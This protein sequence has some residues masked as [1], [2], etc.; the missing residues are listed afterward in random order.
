MK[1]TECAN[2]LYILGREGSVGPVPSQGLV[3]CLP[4]YSVCHTLAT[5]QN[6]D[7]QQHWLCG[8]STG[9]RHK[10]KYAAL[11]HA[12]SAETSHATHHTLSPE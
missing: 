8:V 7:T 5:A 3:I 2:T 9:K 6:N 1:S 11:L 12:G 4:N 10:K